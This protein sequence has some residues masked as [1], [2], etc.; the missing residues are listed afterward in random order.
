MTRTLINEISTFVEAY[1]AEQ[2][3]KQ[4]L[5][6][7]NKSANAFDFPFNWMLPNGTQLKTNHLLIFLICIMLS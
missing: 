2:T 6:D 4:E 7:L 1:E 5:L 3:D